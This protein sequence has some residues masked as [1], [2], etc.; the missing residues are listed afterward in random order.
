[1][2]DCINTYGSFTCRCPIGYQLEPDGIVCKGSVYNYIYSI[3]VLSKIIADVDE[4]AQG[5]CQG[6]DKL[7]VNTLGSFKCQTIECPRNYVLDKRYKK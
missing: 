3:P 5:A 6:G 7:C 4:C 1:M 2:G